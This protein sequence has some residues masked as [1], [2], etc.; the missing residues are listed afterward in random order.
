MDKSTYLQ[1]AER[2]L[3]DCRFYEQLDSD[4]T[5]DI[6]QKIKRAL[7]DMHVRGYIDDKTMQYPTPEDPKSGRFYLLTT[8][9]KE[10]NPGRP[11]V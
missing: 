3:S 2:K 8:I 5:L 4:P 1:E 9:P 10:N 6:T 7:D 11:I